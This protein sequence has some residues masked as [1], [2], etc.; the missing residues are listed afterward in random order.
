MV[1]LDNSSQC[2]RL[3]NGLHYVLIA[4]R[5]HPLYITFQVTNVKAFFSKSGSYL[6]LLNVQDYYN[7]LLFKY[8]GVFKKMRLLVHDSLYYK[9]SPCLDC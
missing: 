6:L 1:T 7:N 4:K 8:S 5:F 2:T 3:I 9:V